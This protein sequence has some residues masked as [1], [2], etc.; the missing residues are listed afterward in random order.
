MFVLFLRETFYCRRIMDFDLATQVMDMPAF[1]DE[2]I[3]MNKEVRNQ[4]TCRLLKNVSNF[5]SNYMC[6]LIEVFKL[7]VS[8]NKL[9]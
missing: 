2:S 9:R 1:D 4:F 3:E 7:F 6:N 5:I 8:E